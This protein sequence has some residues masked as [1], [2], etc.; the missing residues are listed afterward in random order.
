MKECFEANRIE[1]GLRVNFGCLCMQA[2][3]CL[4]LCVFNHIQ[5]D[6]MFNLHFHVKYVSRRDQFVVRCCHHL[7]H[8]IFFLYFTG[9]SAQLHTL[10]TFTVN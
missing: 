6:P 3:A 4:R 7:F 9:W 8:Y 1:R 10:S 2:E 5:C